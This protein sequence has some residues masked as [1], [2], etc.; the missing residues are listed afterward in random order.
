MAIVQQTPSGGGGSG[1]GDKR[2]DDPSKGHY[3]GKGDVN[4]AVWLYSVRPA[5]Q[6]L[7][8]WRKLSQ[9]FITVLFLPNDNR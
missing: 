2:G 7:M 3:I 4:A 5:R 8:Q 9:S 1:G 6:Y